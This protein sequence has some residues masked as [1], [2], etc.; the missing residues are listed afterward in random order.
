MTFRWN[1]LSKREQWTPRAKSFARVYLVGVL[2][3][4]AAAYAHSNDPANPIIF[5]ILSFAVGSLLIITA[6]YGFICQEISW[7]VAGG[8]TAHGTYYGRKAMLVALLHIA[9]VVAIVILTNAS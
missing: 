8:R 9:F 6:Y 4:L 7:V 5:A 1:S 2:V 3:E